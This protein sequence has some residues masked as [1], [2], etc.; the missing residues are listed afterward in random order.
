MRAGEQPLPCLQ[1]AMLELS[2]GTAVS[3]WDGDPS[4]APL[5]LQDKEPLR[6]ILLKDICKTHECLVK[7]G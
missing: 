6:S 4:A 7:S 1:P 5:I 2:T 3:Q